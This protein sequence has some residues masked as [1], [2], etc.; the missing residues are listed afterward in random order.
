MDIGTIKAPDLLAALQAGTVSR[1]DAAKAAVWFGKMHKACVEAGEKETAKVMQ[2][3]LDALADYLVALVEPAGASVPPAVVQVDPP[4]SLTDWEKSHA[5]GVC[6][7][8][9]G[10]PVRL[11][12]HYREHPEHRPVRPKRKVPV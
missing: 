11:G 5:C 1:D 8:V 9:A 7:A 3:V 6:G 4:P 10:N 2:T 12:Q